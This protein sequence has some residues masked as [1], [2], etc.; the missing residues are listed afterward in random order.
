ME[1][2]SSSQGPQGPASPTSWIGVL[3]QKQPESFVIRL[4]AVAGDLDSEQLIRV[5]EVAKKYGGGIVHLTTRQGLEIHNVPRG[6]LA[7]AWSELSQAGLEMGAHGPRVRAIVACPGSL[8]CKKGIM[9]TKAITRLLDKRYFGQEAP[10][11]FKISVTGCPSNCAKATENDCGLM[12]A[13]QPLWEE[14]ACTDCQLCTKLCPAQAIEREEGL[15]R[16]DASRCIECGICISSCKQSSWKVERKG[17]R[18]YVG[19]TMGKTPRFGTLLCDFLEDEDRIFEL[20]DRVLA[21]FRRNGKKKE[22]L[23][24]MI[25]RI[26]LEAF[27]EQLLKKG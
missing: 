12:G 15:Y 4:K 22:R 26:G 8:T 17:F 20:I 16:A 18:L 3:P 7:Q 14:G 9:E 24:H 25:D 2:T 10:A 6:A 13:A 5:G 23:G 27:K 19:G 1:N 11:K 21:Y